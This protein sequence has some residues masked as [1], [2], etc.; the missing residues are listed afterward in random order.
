MTDPVAPSAA[1]CLRF[2]GIRQ[3]LRSTNHRR[4][5]TKTSISIKKLFFIIRSFSNSLKKTMLARLSNHGPLSL[6]RP[7]SRKKVRYVTTFEIASIYCIFHAGA[8]QDQNF[9]EGP[10]VRGGGGSNH[11]FGADLLSPGT[12]KYRLRCNS[13][14]Q[15]ICNRRSTHAVR[16]F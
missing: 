3:P 11:F 13:H 16:P 7:F 8:Y 6:Q 9:D 12:S 5:K 10:T 2:R 15:V 4:L 14:R 1:H